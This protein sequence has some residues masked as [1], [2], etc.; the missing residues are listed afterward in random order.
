VIV[1]ATVCDG[2][3][4]VR[5]DD[6]DLGPGQLIRSTDAEVSAAE[7]SLG[8]RFPAGFRAWM[9]TLGC[10]ILSELVRVYGVPRL[11]EMIVETQARWREYYFWDSSRDLLPKQVVLE[12]I[13]VADTLD[14]DEVIF[15]PSNPDA[16]YLL[17]RHTERICWI[18]ARFEDALEWL[19]TSGVVS[20]PVGSLSFEPSS[21]LRDPLAGRTG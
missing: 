11:L 10:G 8:T 16:L 7:A 9:T 13:I 1:L 14:G 21:W 3:A 19:C 15:H 2:G 20:Q 4:A 12:S 17:P 5:L 6:I 18:G